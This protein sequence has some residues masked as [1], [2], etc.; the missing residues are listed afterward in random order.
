[1]G[2]WDDLEI[3]KFLKR[4]S[5]LIELGMS[6]MD[7]ENMAEKLLYRDRPVSGDDR[8]ICV[9]C[10]HFRPRQCVKKLTP[11]NDLLH[12]CDFFVLRGATRASTG[13]G[14]E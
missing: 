12:R 9:E 2:D 5:K 13:S 11:M 3:Q 6:D 8:R 14:D 7:A 4:S 10:K 1:M